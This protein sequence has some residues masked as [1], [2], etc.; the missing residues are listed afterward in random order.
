LAR[1]TYVGST[2]WMWPWS[3][4]KCDRS[5]Q[6]TQEINAC[7]P[8]PHYGLDPFT[9]RGAPEIDLLEAMP[10]KGTMAYGLKKPYFSASYQVAP[11]KP[12]N[13]PTEGKMPDPGQWYEKG[14]RFGTNATI[15]TFFYGEELKHVKKGQTYVADAISAN[16][17]VTEDHFNEFHDYRLE[18]STKEG[19]Q[20]LRWFLDGQF[21]FEVLAETLDFTGAKMPDEPMH[22]LLNTAV[23]STWG[24]P[25]PCPAGCTCECYDCGNDACDCALPTGFCAMLPAF[26]EVD[27]VRVYQR[28]NEPSEKVGCST[29]NRPT[30]RFIDGHVERYFDPYN[31]EKRPLKNVPKGGALCSKDADCFL[32]TCDKFK[33]CACPKDATGPLCQAFHAFDDIS[34]QKTWHLAMESPFLPATLS[35]ILI[36]LF[37]GTAVL[38][39]LKMRAQLLQRQKSALLS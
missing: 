9:G 8:L 34:Y 36:A 28:P 29:D 13:R 1:A 37:L 21:V 20:S 2:D 5:R 10:G 14:V 26:Y 35:R 19:D 31:G 12:K 4:D 15:N 6:K 17:H 16:R 22:I 18:W 11:G 7:E 33:R 39:L 23:S 24:F 32:G 30:K 27:Y 25:V 3:Y 38:V